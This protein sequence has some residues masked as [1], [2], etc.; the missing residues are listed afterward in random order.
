MLRAVL[1]IAGKDLRH[2]WRE[3]S[4]LF[5][6]LAFPVIF[7]VLFGAIFSGGGGDG[8]MKVA[9]VDMDGSAASARLVALVEASGGVTPHPTESVE[10]ARDLVR[11]G[12]V[13]AALVVPA[14]F[15]TRPPFGGG[16]ADKLVL[17][18]DPARSAETA[19]LQGVLTSAV[20]RQM[21]DI[22]QNRAQLQGWVRDARAS[23]E[24]SDRAGT[25]GGFAD[26]QLLNLAEAWI[27]RADVAGDG[28]DGGEN[29]AGGV[30]ALEPGAMIRTEAARRDD[31]PSAWELTFPQAAAWAMVGCVSGF[32]ASISGERA[33][34]TL[35]RLMSLPVTPAAVIGGKA[36]ACFVSAGVVLGLLHMAAVVVFGVRV[37]SAWALTAALAGSAFA[38]TGLM[39][40]LSVLSRSERGSEGFVR[41]VLLVMALIGGAGVP[42]FFMPAWMQTVASISP[43]R[44]AILALEGA[45]FRAF[46]AGEMALPLA[47]LC[48][49]GVVGLAAAVVGFRRA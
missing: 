29:G 38:F 19:M 6:T 11:R 36:V 37:N 4:V 2:V 34:G 12:T 40:L 8:A 16:E 15:A 35:R 46:S 13:A 1:L 23:L 24:A 18:A 5:F 9:I 21:V 30:A 14:G 22:S 43:F 45:S 41:A 49:L 10:A 20:F 28:E 7:G 26:R 17:I 33:S 3:P 32:G 39:M 44:W 48:G 47:V 25:A 27:A 31:L 42:L